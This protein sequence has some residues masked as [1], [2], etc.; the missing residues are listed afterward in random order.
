MDIKKVEDP[1]VG[2]R[3]MITFDGKFLPVKPF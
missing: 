1:E 2:S 3:A